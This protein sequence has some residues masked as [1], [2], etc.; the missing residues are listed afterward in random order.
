MTPLP[1]T[2]YVLW[3]YD[4]Y[5]FCLGGFANQLKVK[6]N[7]AVSAYVP[8]YNLRFFPFFAT[9]DLDA[10]HR[11]HNALKQL[12]SDHRQAREE[13]DRKWES[14]LMSSVAGNALTYHSR[15]GSEWLACERRYVVY[16]SA[17]KSTVQSPI[18]RA[19]EFISDDPNFLLN[20]DRHVR[21]LCPN[22]AYESRAK[23]IDWDR[24]SFQWSR[25]VRSTHP[26][27]LAFCRTFGVDFQ[28]LAIIAPEDQLIINTARAVMVDDPDN[29][30]TCWIACPIPNNYE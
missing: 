25:D 5:P 14:N 6:P 29:A 21:N 2:H 27:L 8:S 24:K 17:I 30:T 16:S 1:I 9:T 15:L 20:F 23:T 11:I 26:E 7:G 12:E 4:L 13:F 22:V 3:Q 28:H 19:G 10:G 18:Q